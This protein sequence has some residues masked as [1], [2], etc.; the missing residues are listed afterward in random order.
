M[1]FHYKRIVENNMK[2]IFVL[3][4]SLSLIVAYAISCATFP[5][6]IVP[7]EPETQYIETVMVSSDKVYD[8]F[9]KYFADKGYSLKTADESIG[10]IFTN[11]IQITDRQIE[12]YY[13]D[14]TGDKR[15]YLKKGMNFG[16]CDCGIPTIG[17]F[18]KN[19]Y[20]TYAVDISKVD[21]KTTQF[22]VKT[23]FWTELFG[24]DPVIGVV[25]T[26]KGDWDCASSGEYEKKVI[27]EIKT[28]Y[29][30]KK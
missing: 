4:F 6:T 3:L 14:K 5:E 17:L 10:Y 22:S 27:D 18:S 16:Y 25:I 19:L 8:A 7:K 13:R 29:L 11:E 2:R 30:N 24:G 12:L 9:I 26:K 1:V 20:Y 28:N 23:T 21:D 15:E